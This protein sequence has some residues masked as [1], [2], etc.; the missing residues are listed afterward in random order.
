MYTYPRGIDGSS[1]YG[2]GGIGGGPGGTICGDCCG[3]GC[4][5]GGNSSMYRLPWYGQF[6]S[7]QNSMRSPETVRQECLVR[8]DGARLGD[9]VKFERI[10]IILDVYGRLLKHDLS[11]EWVGYGR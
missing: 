7:V 11:K 8:T 2:G 3:G 5:T 10:K 4:C 9:L 6:A 1:S